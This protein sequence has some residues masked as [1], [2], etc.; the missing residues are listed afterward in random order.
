MNYE[1]LFEGAVRAKYRFP[2]K[3]QITTEDLWDLSLQDLDRVF[4]ALNAE[5]KQS[6]EESLL[7]VRDKQAETL[8]RKIEIVKHIVAVKQAEIIAIKEA[9]D[10]KA[11]KQ[12]IM[13]II[14][15][16]E[17]DTLQNMSLD[18]LKKMAENM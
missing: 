4:K 13:E 9:A 7:K 11:Q 10:R 3:G 8:E 5:T 17:D 2:F 16:K 15:K 1:N 6:Q 18:E 14:A 12:R